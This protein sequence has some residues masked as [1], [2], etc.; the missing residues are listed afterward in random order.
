M[1][2]ARLILPRAVAEQMLAHA[3]AEA[4]RECCGLLVGAGM[5]VTRAVPVANV[6]ADARARF[7]ID[8]QRQF[9]L[10]RALRGSAEAVIG[11]YHSHPDALP[12]PSA[13]DL[14]MAHDPEA[15]WIILAPDRPEN[16]VAAYR[17]AD[18]AQGF[19]RLELALA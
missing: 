3:R 18:P 11:H 15:V 6:A 2:D 4:P 16:A 5:R 1:S 14:A 7:E 8:P 9:E 17:C 19:T 12:Q 13:H 10:L